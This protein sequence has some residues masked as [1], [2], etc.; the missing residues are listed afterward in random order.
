MPVKVVLD[1]PGSY[2]FQRIGRKLLRATGAIILAA[3]VVA[4]I[5]AAPATLL[6]LGWL[7]D[8][9]ITIPVDAGFTI[10]ADEI[11]FAWALSTPLAVLGLKHGRRLVRQARTLVLFLR[12]FGDDEA[13]RAVTFSVSRTIGG[14]WRIVTLDDAEIEAVGVPAPTRLVFR[15]AGALS[16]GVRRVLGGLARVAPYVPAVLLAI[17]VS[18]LVLAR[19][20]EHALEPNVWS[21]VLTPFIDTVTAVA[22]GTM[23]LERVGF[24]PPGVFAAIVIAIGWT[25][26]TVM[27][28]GTAAPVVTAAAV[29]A[30]LFVAAPARAVLAAENAKTHEVMDAADIQPTASALTAGTSDFFGPRLVVLRVATPFWR[31]TVRS[32]ASRASVALVDVSEP[33]EHLVWEVEELNANPAISCVFIGHQPDVE[34]LADPGGAE[35]GKWHKE[36]AAIL[37]W[38]EILA[39]T[40]DRAGMRRFARA[41]RNRLMAVP[42]MP[43]RRRRKL[44]AAAYGPT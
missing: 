10:D 43:G 27:N 25:A 15:A 20:W 1:H 9:A 26:H 5:V 37:E 12:R 17:V 11:L 32:F 13:M 29:V 40:T 34:K 3:G 42:A 18:D 44:K 23:P 2:F 22:S 41:L 7:F 16:A 8:E 28:I 24:H 14:A 19:I 21:A 39:Y 6:V 30:L 31:E 4:L 33:S 38:E 35:A 36:L